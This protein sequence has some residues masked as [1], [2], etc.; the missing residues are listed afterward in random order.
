MDDFQK[1]LVEML[2][3][4]VDFLEKNNLRYYVVEG[5]MLGAVRH[6]GLIPWD[7]D[8][9]IG[10]PRADY[11]KLIELLA[12]PV[13]HY[14]IESYK[15]TAKDYVYAFAKF[16]DMNTS[17]TEKLYKNVKR[18]VYIDIF[19]LDAWDSN[20]NKARKEVKRIKHSMFWLSITKLRKAVSSNKL[21]QF[22][23]SFVILFG[24]M[25]TSKLFVNRIIKLAYKN[26]TDTSAYLGCKSWC[27]YGDREIIPAEVFSDSVELEFEGEKFKSPIGYDTYLR[28]L[29]GDYWQ[30]PPIQNQKTHHT[31]KAYKID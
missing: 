6:E 30:D 12:N 25:L 1:K 31:F 24:K 28:S 26:Q 16:Y 15:S 20:I 27:I 10:M 22:V 18:G 5:T 11:E 19:P 17:M 4:L 29:Y 8:V 7:D 3:W 9:D 13:D 2:R 23:M 14:V 21:K